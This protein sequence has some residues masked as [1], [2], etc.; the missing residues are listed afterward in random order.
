MEPK[1]A[2][3][4]ARSGSRSS[5]VSQRS[6]SGMGECGASAAG[7]CSSGCSI[8]LDG[9][10]LYLNAAALAKCCESARLAAKRVSGARGR[11][12]VASGDTRKEQRAELGD[13]EERAGGDD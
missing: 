8:S 4:R 11:L 5:Q 13:E 9:I 2:V 3:A 1:K 7:T 6:P 10:S 12:G